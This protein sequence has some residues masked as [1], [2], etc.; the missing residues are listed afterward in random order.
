MPTLILTLGLLALAP[1]AAARP[2][3]DA[4]IRVVRSDAGG[5]VAMVETRGARLGAVEIGG[6][7]VRAI[8]LEGFGTTVEPGLPVVPVRRFLLEVPP[9]GEVS[10]SVD[11][12][13]V[14]TF[15][16]SLPPAPRTRVD[17]ERGVRVAERDTAPA[18]APRPASFATLESVGVFRHHRVATIR[19]TPV[20]V[21]TIAG[22]AHHAGSL[23]LE[24]RFAGGSFDAAAPWSEDAATP[25]SAAM[26]RLYRQLVPNAHTHTA[27]QASLLG[28]VATPGRLQG[29]PPSGRPAPAFRARIALD[30]TGLYRIGFD[31]L[32]SAGLDPAS[33]DPRRLALFSAKGA[34]VAIHVDGEAD[35]VF[36]PGDRILFYGEAAKGPFTRTNVYWLELD[37]VLHAGPWEAKRW[38]PVDGT[39]DP[40]APIVSAFRARVRAETNAV[41]W[42]GLPDGAGK[43]HW[44]WTKVLG[45][46]S[47]TYPVEIVEPVSP[48]SGSVQVRASL[49]GYTDTPQ[50]PDHH[51][52]VSLNGAVIDDAT[53]NGIAPKLHDVASPVANLAVGT[54]AVKVEQVP[55]TGAIVD[56][57]YADWVEIDYDRSFNAVADEVAFSY[58]SPAPVTLTVRRFD[59]PDLWILD[60][61]DPAN[62]RRIVGATVTTAGAKWSAAMTLAP[63]G[64]PTGPSGGPPG[65]GSR[66][67]A[68]AGGALRAPLSI[69][70]AKPLLSA[71][72]EGA[73]LLVVVPEELAS[74]VEPLV[75]H[76]IAQGWRVAT[77]TPR[78][79]Y[80]SFTGGVEDPAA[81]RWFALW[82]FAYWKKPAPTDLLLCGEASVD[83][84]MHLGTGV[85][86][87]VPPWMHE[88]IQEGEVPSD[89]DYGLLVGDDM[90]PEMFVGRLPARTA[91]ELSTMVGKILARETAPPAGPWRTTVVHIADKGTTFMQTLDALTIQ[92]VPSGFT[93]T[94]IYA[95]LYAT[96]ALT[97]AAVIAALSGGEAVATY[98][99]HGA[100][101]NMGSFFASA[102]VASLT[103]GTKTPFMT[104][105]NCLNGYYASP[106]TPRCLIEEMLVRPGG[107]VA[108]AFG[109]V[110]LGYLGQLT[111][112]AK[113]AY[114]RIFAG[115]TLGSAT[116]GAKVDAFL[117]SGVLSDNLWGNLLFGDPSALGLP[118][119]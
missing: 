38:K 58:A 116:T 41:Y 88:L 26:D 28:P 68:A 22:L 92:H 82:A 70:P 7:R 19:V 40:L 87:H 97:K 110:D 14:T 114:D 42:Q 72:A 100:I 43:D 53:W 95:S 111:P 105:L 93:T 10:L 32:R 39:I 48:G 60:V 63:G 66:Y 24:L 27:M 113:N 90:L 65:T 8:E 67:L 79:I 80:D 106:T 2:S 91:A 12:T 21:D 36:D 86:N 61:T 75:S 78:Q 6:A 33:V 46:A 44:F 119:P 13:A 30:A 16:A 9:G 69:A 45:P 109:S 34:A 51:T 49:H 17:A 77:A 99:G 20:V 18:A 76:R 57:V 55:D 29:A 115:E 64:V 56:G 71:P 15:P 59:S 118:P 81:I 3:A 102:D 83:Y 73:D 107:G 62:V 54:N 104:I 4:P 101:A 94:P 112:I 1:Q 35:G 37:A 103:N 23:R 31:D 74:A 84:L 89:Y 108:A 25:A 117:T 11:A 52:R 98:L 50:D 96:N 5:V 47:T 85:P